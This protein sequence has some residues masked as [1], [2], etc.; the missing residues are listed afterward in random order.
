MPGSLEQVRIGQV[1][2]VH[3]L[4]ATVLMTLA[5]VVLHDFAHGGT[6]RVPHGQTAT[7]F[8]GKRQQVHLDGQS[9]VITLFGFFQTHQVFLQCS[10]G[11]PC[12]A[13][14]ALQGRPFFVAAPMCTSHFHQ[15]KMGESTG[16]GHVRPTTQVDEG[17]AVA[18]HTD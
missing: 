16:A 7:Q 13:V 14:D 15:C 12:R 11:F 10:L 9:T 5:A 8:R 1:R 2:R 6:F 3:K 4:I 17:I 18:I